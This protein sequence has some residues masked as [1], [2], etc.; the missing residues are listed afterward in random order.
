MATI[1]EKKSLYGGEVE[2]VFYPTSHRYKFGKDW[3]PSV[4]SILGSTMDKSRVLMPWAVNMMCQ[5]LTTHF[6]ENRRQYSSDE[7]IQLS[8][9]A[10]SAYR[11]ISDT[12]CN[13][14][15]IVHEYA[16]KFTY[17][18]EL[19]EP[20]PELFD[21][22]H[23]L[24]ATLPEENKVQAKN[25]MEAF[26]KWYIEN[27]ITFRNAERTVYSKKQNYVGT[28]DALA[29]INGKKTLV[30]YKTAKGIYADH[31]LQVSAYVQAHEEEHPDDVIDQ[32]LVLSFNKETGEI[33]ECVVERSDIDA[34]IEAFNHAVALASRIKEL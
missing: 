14:G 33:T 30:D 20:L 2:I 9:E 34:N 7:L 32:A 22:S 24:F 23:E 27:N 8:L 26:I 29:V 4:S 1:T 5:Y 25:G 18:V 16:E 21:D 28:Y 6:E 10:T 15:S 13:V 19:G 3:I 31:K 11:N 17:A 12:A